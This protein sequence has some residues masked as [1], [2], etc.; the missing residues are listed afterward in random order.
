[1]FESHNSLWNKGFFVKQEDQ[2]EREGERSSQIRDRSRP[3]M[4]RPGYG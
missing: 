2:Q 3:F 1:M 4:K